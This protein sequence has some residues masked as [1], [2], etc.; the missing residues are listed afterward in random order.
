MQ[1]NEDPCI[2][3]LGEFILNSLLKLNF[4]WYVYNLL[5]LTITTWM[6]NFYRPAARLSSRSARKLT[7]SG[8]CA[9]L[10]DCKLMSTTNG[11]RISGAKRRDSCSTRWTSLE[12]IFRHTI[13]GRSS[14][15]T[16]TNC[17]PSP[18]SS[19]ALVSSR[20]RF[21]VYPSQGPSF[22][23]FCCCLV[24]FLSLQVAQSFFPTTK[25]G[26]WKVGCLKWGLL[27]PRCSRKPLPRPRCTCCCIT[28]F[29]SSSSTGRSVYWPSRRSSVCMRN[30][31]ASWGANIID[32]RFIFFS[33]CCY[34]IF[35]NWNCWNP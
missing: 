16:C 1:R 4:T 12:S 3:T 30:W 27:F 24:K 32:F 33:G 35:E 6:I 2:S 5:E 25:S 14:A 19:T 15:T 29:R 8:S 22:M 31:T 21:P 7:D 34:L 28:C 11:W 18:T 9:T 13:P 10:P 20:R 26:H 17:S 23:T